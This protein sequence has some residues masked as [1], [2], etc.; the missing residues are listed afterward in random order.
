MQPAVFA[1][2]EYPHATRSL[3]S[4]TKYT[5]KLPDRYQTSDLEILIST[6]NQTDFSFLERMFPFAPYHQFNILIINQTKSDQILMSDFPT[7]R[8]LNSK[9]TGLSKSRNLALANASKNIVLIAD[10]D[11]IYTADFDAKIIDA[12]NKNPNAS[13]IH[14]QTQTTEN[15]LFW[16]Y[17]KNYKKLHINQL[18]NVLSVEIAIKTADIKKSKIRF[19]ELFGLGAQFEDAE[20]FF[21]LRAAFHKKKEVLFYPETI[22]MHPSFTSSDEVESDRKIYAKMAGFQKRFGRFSYILL[23]KYIFFLIRKRFISF[24]EIKT[25]FIIGL[26]GINDYQIFSK[27]FTDQK[28]D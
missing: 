3:L 26:K 5:D 28:Y 27:E 13:V 9:E 10:D 7:V 4:L 24:K 22:V 1:D 25:K 6:Q 12:F 14:F 8:I 15:K 2:Q 19:N 17:P 20:S 18:T 23:C 11:V 16:N 21:F